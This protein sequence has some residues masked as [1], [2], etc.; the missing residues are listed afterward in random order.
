MDMA[1]DQNLLI[2]IGS[3]L[4]IIIAVIIYK[5]TSSSEKEDSIIIS[6]P[7][8][9]NED[10]NVIQK[11]Q[12]EDSQLNG[13]QKRESSVSPT[14]SINTPQI[15]IKANPIEY[16]QLKPTLLPFYLK[17]Q[18]DTNID[19]LL[20]E[21]QDLLTQTTQKII[22]FKQNLTVT[23]PQVIDVFHSLER[24]IFRAIKQI[25]SS[26]VKLKKNIESADTLEEQQAF[27]FEFLMKSIE[28][29]LITPVV[30][31]VLHGIEYGHSYDIKISYIQFIDDILNPLYLNLGI[32]T[33]N[34]EL[35]QP[36][37]FDLYLPLPIE[38]NS[39]E[40]DKIELKECLKEVR[41]Y[42]YLFDN[43]HVIAVGQAI[44]WRYVAKQ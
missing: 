16:F 19:D 15:Q 25:E 28:S 9:N 38:D 17:F 42:A 12:S 36:F 8:T 14:P 6:E 23:D 34:I 13:I 35:N 43:E 41:Q 31:S 33:K 7:T 26:S 29:N 20:K 27:F 40:T 32:K 44:A 3:I 11:P 39:N 30:S 10:Q 5:M 18:T 24:M 22:D 4:A 37:D 1:I 2:I 21:Y